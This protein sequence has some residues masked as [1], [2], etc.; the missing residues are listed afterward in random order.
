M[1]RF[2]AKKEMPCHQQ[3]KH[4]ASG[5]G[6]GVGVVVPLV[7]TWPPLPSPPWLVSVWV[8]TAGRKKINRF[9]KVKQYD[10]YNQRTKDLSHCC[11]LSMY[12]C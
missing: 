2:C 12:T 4:G 8:V 1:S 5:D 7:G 10:C 9:K 11:F 6:V 3:G